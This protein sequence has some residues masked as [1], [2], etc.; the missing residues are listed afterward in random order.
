L[1][2]GFHCNAKPKTKD[3][4]PKTWPSTEKKEAI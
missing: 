2:I 4:R 1:V 3:P